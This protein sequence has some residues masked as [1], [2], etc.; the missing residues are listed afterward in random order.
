VRIFLLS[1]AILATAMMR[2]AVGDERCSIHPPQDMSEAQ[3]SGLAKLTKAEAEKLAMAQL[4]S[5]HSVST[6]SAELESEHGCLIWSFD[7]RVAG[8]S[9]VQEIQID[10]GNGKVLSRKHESARTEAAETSN[11]AYP[12]RQK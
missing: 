8:R 10:A 1:S 11:E 4:G 6:S 12:T 2:P 7:F 5:T 9:G 3:L